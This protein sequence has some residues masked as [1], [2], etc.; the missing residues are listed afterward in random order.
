MF[1]HACDKGLNLIL[2]QLR[3]SQKDKPFVLPNHCCKSLRRLNG[4]EVRHRRQSK[5]RLLHDVEGES[6]IPALILEEGKASI[7]E[8]TEPATGK[9]ESGGTGH[10]ARQLKIEL[11]GHPLFDLARLRR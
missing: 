11:G 8:G 2:R 1:D 10:I 4:C 7:E 9:L 5:S 6:C 3:D